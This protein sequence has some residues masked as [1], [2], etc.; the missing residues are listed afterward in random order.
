[1]PAATQDGAARPRR[2]LTI[3]Q[4]LLFALLGANALVMFFIGALFY[5]E[6]KTALFGE[7]DARLTAFALGFVG[8]VFSTAVGLWV[9][10]HFHRLYRAFQERISDLEASRI[11]LIDQRDSGRRQAEKLWTM[12]EQRYCG[13]L[14]FA[15]DGILVG[16]PDG[17]I[18]EAN[19]RMSELFRLA[20]S[21]MVGKHISHMPFTAKS[22]AEN[23]LRF[24]LL[25]KGEKVVT[26]RTIRRKD[27]SEVI[28]EMHSKQMP[29]GTLQS[30]Y[31][32]ITGRKRA[33]QEL[34]KSEQ[35]YKNLLKG[36]SI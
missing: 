2:R 1:M 7:L 29:D 17:V 26:E 35:R 5:A 24:D 9:A 11:S 32:D 15:V 23:P 14:D 10:R 20:R 6:K 16:T 36:V 34:L 8:C 28:I 31:R 33:E 3:H 22:L 13:L 27:G 12:S 4:Q 18:I 30:F 25:E 19:E 21:E